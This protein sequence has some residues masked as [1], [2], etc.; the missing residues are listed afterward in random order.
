M[1]IVRIESSLGTGI[2]LIVAGLAVT[3]VLAFLLRRRLP[4][5]VVAATLAVS[6]AAIGWGGLLL[7]EDRSA[8]ENALVLVLMIVLVPAH[9]RIVLGPFGPPKT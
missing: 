2:G 8:V 5:A 3:L 7:L 1:P 4:P 6:G 9:V